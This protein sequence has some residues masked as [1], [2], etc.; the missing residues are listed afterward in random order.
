MAYPSGLVARFGLVEQDAV[1]NAIR[2]LVRAGLL[3]RSGEV[4]LPT[5]AAVQLK[6]LFGVIA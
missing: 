6:E 1:R 4:V 2:E 5:Q 3:H